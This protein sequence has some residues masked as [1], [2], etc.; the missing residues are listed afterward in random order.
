MQDSYD[1]G[2][3]TIEKLAKW[4]AEELRAMLTTFVGKTK[5][6]GIAPLPKEVKSAIETAR[7]LPRIVEY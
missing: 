1:S 4:D 7:T 2:V 6:N 5:F 3:D